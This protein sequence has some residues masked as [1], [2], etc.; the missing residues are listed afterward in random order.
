MAATPKKSNWGGARPGAGRKRF[1]NELP[2]HAREKFDKRSPV[3][4]T[5][6]VGADGPNLRDPRW[7]PVIESVLRVVADDAD[8]PICEF[9]ALR[10]R[11]CFLVDA[12]NSQALTH[13][14]S[15]VIIRVARRFN[16]ATERSG[17]LF[18]DRYMARLLPNA[19]AVAE[20][21][22]LIRDGHRN[23]LREQLANSKMAPSKREAAQAIVNNKAWVDPCS[24]RAPRDDGEAWPAPI[25]KLLRDGADVRKASKTRKA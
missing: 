9:V 5:V 14:M 12:A 2:H 7:Y 17:R 23:A 11:L 16:A 15:S 4:V 1:S 21:R 19:D 18:A 8:A 20:A 10:D 24:S 22:A 6:A 3:L 25:C 13:V